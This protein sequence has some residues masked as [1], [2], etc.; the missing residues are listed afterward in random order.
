MAVRAC[1]PPGQ[2]GPDQRVPAQTG[3]AVMKKQQEIQIGGTYLAKVGARSVEVK[4]DGENPKGGWNATAVAT[5]KPVRV[6]DARNLRPVK[7]MAAAGE[8]S[9][10]EPVPATR[11]GKGAK[12]AGAK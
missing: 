7:V 5:G 8:S 11:T 1:R 3:E 12:R 6:K 2:A 10:T 9:D 4:V